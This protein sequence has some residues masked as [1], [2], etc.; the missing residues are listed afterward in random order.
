MFWSVW[1]SDHSCGSALWWR[2]AGAADLC[3]RTG[4]ALVRLQAGQRL[5][6]GDGGQRATQ[7]S[8]RRRFFFTW[9]EATTANVIQRRFQPA[10]VVT[11]MEN[12]H[13]GGSSVQ[14]PALALDSAC[15]SAPERTGRGPCLPR[16]APDSG[17]S[18]CKLGWENLS[19]CYSDFEAWQPFNTVMTRNI[20]SLS[21][22]HTHNLKSL[23]A[24]HPSI[25][26]IYQWIQCIS[27]FHHSTTVLMWFLA[28]HLHTPPTALLCSSCTAA[29]PRQLR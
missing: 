9:R 16:S 20:C 1:S 19:I 15:A 24:P 5:V 13:P 22:T 14:R 4:Q 2:E 3:C 6:A 8:Q 7:A 10:M 18:S 11:G 12:T 17:S 25:C 23:M 26:F 29:C 28:S 27:K 21:H